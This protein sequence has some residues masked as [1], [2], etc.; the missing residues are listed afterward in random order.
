VLLLCMS[1]VFLFSFGG[2]R[3]SDMRADTKIDLSPV[4]DAVCSSARQD[5]GL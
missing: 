3:S 4:D 1:P 5:V 2:K